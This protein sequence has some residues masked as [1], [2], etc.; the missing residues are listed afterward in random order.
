[1]NRFGQGAYGLVHTRYFIKY[2]DIY[3]HNIN[4]NLGN[5]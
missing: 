3:K 5:Q 1:M 4:Q 2:G